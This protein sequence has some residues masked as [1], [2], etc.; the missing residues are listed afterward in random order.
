M[1]SKLL[2]LLF[3]VIC[4]NSCYSQVDITKEVIELK[5]T[6]K[7]KNN[8]IED[9]LRDFESKEDFKNWKIRKKKMLIISILKNEENDFTI[10]VFP[11]VREVI[12]FH[13]LENNYKAYINKKEYLIVF[14]GNVNPFLKKK[15]KNIL[16]LFPEKEIVEPYIDEHGNEMIVIKNT[17]IYGAEYFVKNN[18]IKF[19]EIR[20]FGSIE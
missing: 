12:S 19:N 5:S 7:F 11:K 6:H 1:R 16:K 10:K 20:F 13:H 8:I 3:I 17:E 18:K 2:R 4:A 15:S 14:Y 9:I